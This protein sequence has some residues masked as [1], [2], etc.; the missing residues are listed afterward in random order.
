M[1]MIDKVLSIKGTLIQILKSANIFVFLWKYYAED[2]IL[3]YLLLFETYA[4]E[5]W[6]NF[7][8]ILSGRIEYVKN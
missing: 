5:I 6:E 8:Y 7:L 2:F 1:A 4:R 3:K